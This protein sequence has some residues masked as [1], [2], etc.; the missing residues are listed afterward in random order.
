MKLVISDFYSQHAYQ[1][2]FCFVILPYVTIA[3]CT[4]CDHII[5]TMWLLHAGIVL[6][7]RGASEVRVSLVRFL[8]NTT[9]TLLNNNTRQTMWAMSKQVMLQTKQS[10]D[11][12]GTNLKTQCM[13]QIQM[14][15]GKMQL[16][17]N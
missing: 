5:S 3:I 4:V 17:L 12:K 2:A 13:K 9:S 8:G 15:L 1:T 6:L 16:L 10:F 11:S 7:G 14:A